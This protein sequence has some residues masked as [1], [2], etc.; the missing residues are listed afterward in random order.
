M[1][2]FRALLLALAAGS[3]TLA[4]A[5]SAAP[6]TAPAAPAAVKP[7]E[8]ALGLSIDTE[9]ADASVQV[10]ALQQEVFAAETLMA[11]VAFRQEYG[12]RIRAER[13]NIPTVD[14]GS[15]PAYVF[16]P[17]TAAEGQRLPGLVVVHGSYHGSFGPDIF[18]LIARAVAEGY[19]VIFPEYRGS[20]GYGQEH[21]DAIDFGGK[22]VDDV[23]AAADYL[24]ERGLAP[25]DRTAIYG[26]SKGGMV[27]LLAIE[28]F[29]KRFKAAVD[30]VGIADMVAYMAYKPGFRSADVAKQPMF[31]G[32]SIAQDA[33]PYIEVSPLNHI[34][35]IETPLL[36]EGTTGDKTAPVQLHT[37]RVVELLKAY[38]KPFESKI[39][40]QAPGGHVFSEVDSAQA[41]DSEDRVFDFLKRHMN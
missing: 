19:C 21:Y 23:V 13:V 16:R 40:D 39:Y 29:P 22:E 15:E 18:P 38:G 24:A 27:A 26:R 10:K 31:H 20:R 36:V 28:R 33:G 25:A 14:A 32:K 35:D 6:A 1:S 9:A 8:G 5:A 37:G 2:P 11:L 34:K 4:A 41:R 30:V 3:S 17:K 7:H 12:E